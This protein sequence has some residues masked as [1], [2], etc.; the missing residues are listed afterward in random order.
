MC[1]LS[2]PH[3]DTG[4]MECEVRGGIC[5]KRAT[6]TRSLALSSTALLHPNCNSTIVST[7][8]HLSA[9]FLVQRPLRS[10]SPHGSSR[11]Q[12]LFDSIAETWMCQISYDM[13]HFPAYEESNKSIGGGRTLA[14]GFLWLRVQVGFC[15]C[16]CCSSKGKT[17]RL[18]PQSSSH[19]PQGNPSRRLFRWQHGQGDAR[20]VV[21]VAH[22]Q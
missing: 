22:D 5:C 14:Q 9:P 16:N 7:K 11:H 1:T 12:D 19:S 3:S 17:D 15:L 10:P 6:R 4:R 2:Q 20:G 8:K 13:F 21:Y 18:P